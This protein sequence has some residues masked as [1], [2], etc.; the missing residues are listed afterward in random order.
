MFFKIFKTI[1]FVPLIHISIVQ[2]YNFYN[3]YRNLSEYS[4]DFN[5]ILFFHQKNELSH[6]DNSLIYSNLIIILI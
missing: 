3:E 2:L 1:S 4:F 5:K 6:C